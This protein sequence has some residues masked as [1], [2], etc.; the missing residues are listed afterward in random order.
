MKK[1]KF[2][3]RIKNMYTK[4]PSD[5]NDYIVYG[6]E[7]NLPSYIDLRKYCPKVKDIKKNNV[8]KSC[9]TH[10]VISCLETMIN[11]FIVDNG[12]MK[13]FEKNK[14]KKKNNFIEICNGHDFSLEQSLYN[15]L[16]KNNKKISY[17]YIIQELK[18]NNYNTNKHKIEIMEYARVKTD[19][20]FLINISYL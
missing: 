7:I 12:I 10:V 6:I 16:K 17:R 11:I 15:N 5:D 9:M 1:W 14:R 8:I 2:D 19:D 4:D 18:K 3:K 20:N 13:Y